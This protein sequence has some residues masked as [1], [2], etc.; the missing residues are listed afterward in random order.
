MPFLQKFLYQAKYYWIFNRH[1]HIEK[2]IFTWNDS[3]GTEYF[4]SGKLG[5]MNWIQASYGKN[6]LGV[7]RPDPSEKNA[8]PEPN[9][10]RIF[11]KN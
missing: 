8:R 4:V 3:T 2:M 11:R 1:G 9:P 7:A 10:A 6:K 5:R